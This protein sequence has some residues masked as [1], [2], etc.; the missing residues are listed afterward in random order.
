M[1]VQISVVQSKQNSNF[2]CLMDI[3][4]VIFVSIG[5]VHVIFV[6]FCLKIYV[7]EG[8]S[9]QFQSPEKKFNL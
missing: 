7:N 9:V 1:H 5:Q 3:P 8:I 6:K 2:I 4:K